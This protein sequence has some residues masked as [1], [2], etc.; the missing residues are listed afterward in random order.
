M[1]VE[2]SLLTISNGVGKKLLLEKEILCA[3]LF[4]LG[5]IKKLYAISG[6]YPLKRE[7]FFEEMELY[8]LIQEVQELLN[9]VF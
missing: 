6:R 9:D 1:E 8:K 7:Y 3:E 5:K 4:T 2:E